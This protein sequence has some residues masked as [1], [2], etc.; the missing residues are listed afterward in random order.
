MV[1]TLLGEKNIQLATGSILIF[2]FLFN[3]GNKFLE[4][5]ETF[6]TN[7]T[8]RD[9]YEGSHSAKVTGEA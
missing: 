7:N 1:K 3:Q 6:F 5:L 8:R 2:F 4:L 9:F